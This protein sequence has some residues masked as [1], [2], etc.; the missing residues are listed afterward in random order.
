M[1]LY[2]LT[3]GRVVWDSLPPVH[4]GQPNLYLEVTAKNGKIEFLLQPTLNILLHM[5][6]LPIGQPF[7]Q[8]RTLKGVFSQSRDVQTVTVHTNFQTQGKRNLSQNGIKWLHIC[9]YIYHLTE[10][11]NKT[12]WVTRVFHTIPSPHYLSQ[13]CIA[14]AKIQ[15]TSSLRPQKSSELN[16]KWWRL[17]LNYV[18]MI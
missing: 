2:N 14:T 9:T 8:I 6:D 15:N 7:F 18:T 12:C 16:E 3:Y 10:T 11:S 13:A 5:I 1:K 4:S 17:L